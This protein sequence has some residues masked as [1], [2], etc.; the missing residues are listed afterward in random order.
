[1]ACNSKSHVIMLWHVISMKLNIGKKIT[2]LEM[3]TSDQKKSACFQTCRT[4]V[5]GGCFRK[6]TGREDV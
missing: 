4:D 6:Q 5:K 1:M 2:G 3:M